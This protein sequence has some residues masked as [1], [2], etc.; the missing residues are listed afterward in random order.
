MSGAELG[1]ESRAAAI[2]ALRERAKAHNDPAL[3]A[4]ADGAERALDTLM[5]EV[6][7]L[8]SRLAASTSQIEREARRSATIG[9]VSETVNSSLELDVVL[10]RVL[11]IA[12]EVMNAQRG[13]IMIAD[14]ANDALTL[15][16]TH[17]LDSSTLETEEMRPS[18]TTVRRVFETGE[19]IFTT[20]A[21]RDPR[22]NAQMSVRALKL[23]SIICVPLTVKSHRIG[24]MYL[25]SR[26]SAGLFT[27]QDPELLI[28]FANQAALAIENAR[29]FDEQ[30]SRLREIS[31]LEEF[32]ARVLSS[33]TDGVITIDE[34]GTITSFNDAAA[35]T[36]GVAA[37]ALPG[38]PIAALEPFIP[39]IGVMIADPTLRTAALE[40]AGRHATN[41]DLTLS[42]RIAT[43]DL[44]DDAVGT[45]IALTDL[46]QQRDLE[47]LHRADVEH[48]I[49]IRD[50][51]SRYVAPHV[52]ESLINAPQSVT[53]GGER[54]VATI[55]F[56]DIKGFT[57]LA[58]RMTAEAVV[59]ILNSYFAAAVGIVF[60]HN[61]LLDKF[62]GDGLMAVFGPPLVRGDDPA[63]ALAAAADLHRV[64]AVLDRPGAPMKIS[65]GIASGDVVAGHIGSPRRMDYT[66]IG[67]AVN[68]AH[69]L[70]GAA[71]AGSTF[72]DE[73]T[74]RRADG[75]VR[76]DR[77]EATVKGRD[78][79]VPVYRIT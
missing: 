28:A 50:A 8:A 52:V 43:I 9:R 46:T 39:Q 2:A 70:Q 24:V 38:L 3:A 58:G 41:G 5:L 17:G 19:P 62:Y 66:V 10:R 31:R 44:G 42:L 47:R 1:T 15:T 29:L 6:A 18:Q 16:T 20:D 35:T 63:R 60:K 30:G 13:F 45:A 59:E 48:R 71:P 26:V 51:F 14:E 78:R 40:I 27:R 54:A 61:G 73:V 25:D 77:F 23:R 64:A 49:H 53:L 12:V 36:L 55:L 72:C 57:E 56:A 75:T 4:A 21:Q 33:I 7:S 74:F 32:Q 37:D 34:A 69:R 79:L 22:F 11:D 67:D 65:I 68:L 76:G